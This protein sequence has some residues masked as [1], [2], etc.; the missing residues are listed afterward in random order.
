MIIHETPY[1]SKEEPNN[2]ACIIHLVAEYKIFHFPKMINHHKNRII[3]PFD[4]LK[5]KKK[6]HT[7][8]NI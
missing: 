6:I 5:T 2:I 1:L 4:F 3:T 7:L 8:E